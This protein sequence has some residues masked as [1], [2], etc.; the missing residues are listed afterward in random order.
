MSASDGTGIWVPGGRVWLGVGVGLA[1]LAVLLRFAWLTN[2]SLWYDEG[3]S[4][5]FST[6]PGIADAWNRISSAPGSE[7]YQP[8]YY[9]V[10]FLWRAVFGSG[11]AALRVLS[12]IL[13]SGAVLVLACTAGR[14]FGRRHALWTLALGATAATAVYYSQEVRPYALVL[15]VGALQLAAFLELDRADGDGT[16][17]ARWAFWA[18]S[19]LAFATSLLLGLFAASM[20]IAELAV[21]R[22]LRR[23]IRR[24][25]PVAI[26]S[27]PFLAYYAIGFLS[28]RAGE[29]SAMTGSIIRNAGFV[30][31]GLLVGTTYGPSVEDLHGPDQIGIVLGYWPSLVAFALVAIALAVLA[32]RVLAVPP[33]RAQ[34]SAIRLLTVTLVVAFVLAFG[35]ALVARLNWQPRHSIYLLLPILLLLPA[36]A[37]PRSTPTGGT[38][39][40]QAAGIAAL[41]AFIALNLFSVGHYFLDASYARDDYRA[42]AAYLSEPS[43]RDEPAVLLWGQPNLLAYYG[44]ADTIDGRTLDKGRIDEEIERVT[45]S[46]PEVIVAINRDFYW[47][48]DGVTALDSLMSRRYDLGETRAFA[49]FSVRTYHLRSAGDTTT[50]PPG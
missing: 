35:F 48:P 34:G 17:R 1:V 14:T 39:R 44:A 26:V 6:G 43:N 31:Y 4:L 19:A 29:I 8:L 22:D 23:A 12:A 42:A 50:Q 27:L 25:L 3:F 24:W 46:S 30:P 28:Q 7:R 33:D 47:D 41:V 49:Y 21:R 10:L 13:G 45:A 32:V 20:L 38:S 18:A 36:I 9:L 11:E 15:F 40:W 16:P 5:D 2:Q 37:M